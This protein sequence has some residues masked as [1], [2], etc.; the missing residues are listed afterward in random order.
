MISG[1][2]NKPLHLCGQHQNCTNLT[3]KLRRANPNSDRASCLPGE[4]KRDG[5]RT[6]KSGSVSVQISINRKA[7]EKQNFRTQVASVPAQ[8]GKAEESACWRTHHLHPQFSLLSLVSEARGLSFKQ[9]PSLFGALNRKQMFPDGKVF[10]GRQCNLLFLVFSE[11]N[12]HQLLLT[13]H[14]LEPDSNCPRE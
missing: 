4:S 5:T 2:L 7:Q 9:V 6:Q 12:E 3:T 1:N 11:L 10:L 14:I 8:Q 13:E